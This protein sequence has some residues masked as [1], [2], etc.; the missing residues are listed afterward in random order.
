[1]SIASGSG[2]I[3]QSKNS[4]PVP[5]KLRGIKKM[6]GLEEKL[7]ETVRQFPVLYDTSC[8]NFKDNSKKTLAFSH[9][10]S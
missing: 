2:I 7:V 6:A 10:I 8:R 9:K 5:F 4:S 3:S 1:V